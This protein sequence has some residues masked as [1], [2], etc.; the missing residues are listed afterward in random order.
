MISTN[1]SDNLDLVKS[2]FDAWNRGD[3]ET[4]ADH[5]V[6]DV[7]WLEVSGR[8][9]GGTTERRGRDRM[10]RSLESLFEAWESYRLEPEE[11]HDLGDRVLAVVREVGRG[12][13]IAGVG[14]PRNAT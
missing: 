1:R 5:A 10:R 4:F 6:E 13:Q 2:A 7:A 3:I 14:A 12:L 11:I 9:E 8:P